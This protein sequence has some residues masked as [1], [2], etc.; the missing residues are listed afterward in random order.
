MEP[1]N[2]TARFQDGKL[3]LWA[4]TQDPEGARQAVARRSR[5][6]EAADITVNMVRMGGAFGR[7]YT[8]DFVLEAA[9]IAKDDG[10]TGE[11]AVD[12][13]GRHAARLLSSRRFPLLEG[14]CGR[15]GQTRRVA[16]PLRHASATER[17]HG[18]ECQTSPAAN[19]RRRFVPNFA[20]GRSM[21]PFGVPTGPLRAPGSNAIAFVDAVVPRRARARRGEGPA[22]VPPRASCRT[23]HRASGGGGRGGQGDFDRG[24]RAR[25]ARTGGGEVGLGKAP[26]RRRA[27]EWASRSTTAIAATSPRSSRRRVS[28]QQGGEG[29]P[30]LGRRRRRQPDHQPERRRAAGAGLRARRARWRDGA[31]DHDRP[32]R[33]VQS[34]FHNY[35]LLRLNQSRRRSRCTSGAP[36]IRRRDGRAGIPAGRAGAVQRDLRR[37]G[38]AGSVAA[39]FEGWISL[40]LML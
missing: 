18:D 29:E 8:H 40:G 13:R 32:G 36:R 24:A 19:F 1:M 10:H 21:M 38:R 14:W 9:W 22:A 17:A 34:N 25:R 20:T 28:A 30:R 37:D 39:A 16:K 31:G 4:P 33:V 35:P 12:A 2:C 5:N 27:P 6:H 11:A 26:A 15:V 3:E 23:L 7:R